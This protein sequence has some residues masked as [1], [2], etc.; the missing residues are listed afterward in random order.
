MVSAV[1]GGGFGSKSGTSMATP[2]VA[3]IAVLWAQRQR[4]MI[5]RVENRSLLAQLIASGTTVPLA[6]NVEEEDVGT[7]IVQAPLSGHSKLKACIKAEL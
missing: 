2:H 3:G 1:P 5:G 6:S 4:D 7:G